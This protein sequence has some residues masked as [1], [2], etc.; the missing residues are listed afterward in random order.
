MLSSKVLKSLPGFELFFAPLAVE[1]D[2]TT[3]ERIGF[4]YIIS[5]Y[6]HA[7]QL[8]DDGTRYFD[9]PK[10]TAWIYI[11]EFGGLNPR[12]IIDLLLHDV[13]EDTYLLSTYRTRLNF[14]KEIALDV[15]A[16]TK[17]P[18][19]KET[20]EKYLQRVIDRGADIIF[21]KLCDRLHNLRSLGGCTKEKRL[22]QIAE[23]KQYFFGLIS[24]LRSYG[25]EWVGMAKLMKKKMDEAIASYQLK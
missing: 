11:N 3:L 4:A 24:I 12:I 25:G 6:G 17:L 5:K 13:Q 8:R 2:P 7:Q 9:H 18:K 16:V 10:S 14:G 22:K 23:T 15:R 1:F 21:V 19:G 20:M